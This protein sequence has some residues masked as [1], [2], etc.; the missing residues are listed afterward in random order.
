VT[1]ITYMPVVKFDAD[2]V[3]KRFGEPAERIKPSRWAH[4][5]YP[6]WG[7]DLLLGDNG[8]ALLQ[9]VPPLEFEQRLRAPLRDRRT[10]KS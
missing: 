9:Y 5:L 2:L 1:A 7:L 4:W 6:G 3:R 8:E 10:M